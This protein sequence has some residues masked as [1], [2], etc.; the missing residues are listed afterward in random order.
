LQP[1]KVASGDFFCAPLRPEKPALRRILKNSA[2][3]LVVASEPQ[4]RPAPEPGSRLQLFIRLQQP[5]VA[6]ERCI[7]CGVCEHEC[8]VAGER[9]IRVSAEN[10]TRNRKHRMLI[11]A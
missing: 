9:A 10:E 11:G 8:P 2:D 7:G 6:P 5:Y 4:W 3:T 1:E